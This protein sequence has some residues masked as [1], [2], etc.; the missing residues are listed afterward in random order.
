MVSVK[1]VDQASQTSKPEVLFGWDEFRSFLH[2][3]VAAM[4]PERFVKWVEDGAKEPGESGEFHI[5]AFQRGKK[6]PSMLITYD[7]RYPGVLHPKE[8]VE[9]DRSY[10]VRV[11]EELKP[12]LGDRGFC[13]SV[14][15]EPTFADYLKEI[16]KKYRT[17][18]DDPYQK[19][20][21]Q[22]MAQLRFVKGREGEYKVIGFIDQEEG[23]A[24]IPGAQLHKQPEAGEHWIAWVRVEQR[25]Y[26]AYDKRGKFRKILVADRLYKRVENWN[27]YDVNLVDR[28]P[29]I[30]IRLYKGIRRIHSKV[31]RISEPSDLQKIPSQ[32]PNRERAIFAR[33]WNIYWQR[34]VLGD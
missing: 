22:F 19:V 21:A 29:A 26:N 30:A 23:K 10:V 25:T 4:S 12:V 15:R 9:V 1:E 32:L 17:F 33:L 13:L 6:F 34:E 3:Q 16:S 28:K 24:V 11:A 18:L 20:G 27:Q 14:L 5:V 8:R 2:P 7:L 31:L